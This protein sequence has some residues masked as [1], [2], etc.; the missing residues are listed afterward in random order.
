MIQLLNVC[1]RDC[2]RVERTKYSH[3]LLSYCAISEPHRSYIPGHPSREAK[4]SRYRDWGVYGWQG[5]RNALPSDDLA[6]VL[7]RARDAGVR[8]QIIT[9]GSLSESKG[10]LQLAKE[11]GISTSTYASQSLPWH[12]S[13]P[14]C[15]RAIC[16]YRVSSHAK[17]GDEQLSG[18]GS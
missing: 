11:H 2:G 17:L 1:Q 15:Y 13:Y 18:I 14:F 12:H 16:H 4:A 6:A 9:G 7:Q 5:T 10:A 8:S 3:S